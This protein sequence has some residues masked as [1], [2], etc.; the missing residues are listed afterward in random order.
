MA[1]LTGAEGLTCL[2]VLSLGYWVLPVAL[3]LAP[4]K[5]M[6]R[7]E[8]RTFD[9]LFLV[10]L[11]HVKIRESVIGLSTLRVSVTVSS[12][13]FLFACLFQHRLLVLAM[14]CF[15]PRMICVQPDRYWHCLKG[16][17]GETAERRGGARM[18]LSER[19]DAILS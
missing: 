19:Y 8:S 6:S 16:N 13:I 2:S 18:G 4:M 1:G 10:F 9:R 12:V 5:L 11:S 3:Q 7:Y 15:W 17:L 14:N